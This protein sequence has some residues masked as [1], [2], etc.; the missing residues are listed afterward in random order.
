MSTGLGR[1]FWHLS[2]FLF[3]I[4]LG[5]A[6]DQLEK[7]DPGALLKY[8]HIL[9]PLVLDMV[10]IRIPMAQRMMF[11]NDCIGGKKTTRRV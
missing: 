6:S 9:S 7:T 11:F 2:P 3:H 8:W 5:L 10:K 4:S 1:L